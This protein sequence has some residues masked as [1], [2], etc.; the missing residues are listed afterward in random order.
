MLELTDDLGAE[1]FLALWQRIATPATAASLRKSAID[2]FLRAHRIRRLDGADVL[3][4][5]RQKP[6]VVAPGTTEAACSHIRI[7]TARLRLINAQLRE[8]E[9]HLDE[10]CD[11]LEQAEE[12]EPGQSCEQRDVT[13]LRSLPGLGRIILATLLAEAWE[14]LQRRDYHALRSLCA[15]APV[16]KRSGKVRFVIRRL[17]C[18]KRLAQALYHWARVATQHDPTC[19]RRYHE[20]RQRGH[21]H[22]RAL[23]TVGDRLLAVACAML[24]N[25]SLFD[26]AHAIQG[27]VAA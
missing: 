20:L 3:R 8:A 6:L 18:D 25:R 13:I 5:L 24:Q 1:W 2:S 7:L 14:P 23:R 19:K 27:A 9:R 26:P 22:A 11:Q 17:A 12:S 16:T 21:S 4:I 10:L 15:V